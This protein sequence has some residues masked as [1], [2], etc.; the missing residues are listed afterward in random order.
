MSCNVVAALNAI[1]AIYNIIG[2]D[3]FKLI[4]TI[5]PKDEEFVLSLVTSS[6]HL[7]RTSMIMERIRRGGKKSAAE[8]A[9]PAE[10]AKPKVCYRMVS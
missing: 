8:S 6:S 10:P 2:D 5:A 4:G 7:T 3:V 1:L 9:A